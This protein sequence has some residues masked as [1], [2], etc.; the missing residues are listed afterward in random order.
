MDPITLAMMGGTAITSLLGARQADQVNKTNAQ[1]SLMNFYEQQRANRAAEREGRRQ[2]DEAKLGTTDAM[3]N[4]TRFIPGVGWV[5][6]LD[7]QQQELADLTQA[8]QRRQLTDETA[9]TAENN[10]RA[11]DRRGREDT[12][13]TE[14]ERELRA[15]R[16]GDEGA[17]RQL[18]LARG[19][20]MRNRQ[21]DRAGDAAARAATRRGGTNAA[22]IAQG[23]RASSDAAAARQA[24]VDAELAAREM[25]DREFAGARDAGRNLYDY[26]RRSSTTGAMPVTGVTPSGPSTRG[27]GA[28]DQQFLNVLSRSPAMMDYQNTNNAYTDAA[29]GLMNMFTQY[30]GMNNANEEAN[31]VSGN[32]G[33]WSST[34]G[35][36]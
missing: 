23:A 34:Q 10:E 12:L 9:R 17:L 14:A 31:R 27:T 24:G 35:I 30:R 19:A 25:T 5:T 36:R 32:S 3:G 4:R 33:R 2:Q 29:Q 16:R 18:L 26:F 15:A 8:E 20:E 1:I 22:A 7:E 6:E 11:R 21:A 13:A 28:A